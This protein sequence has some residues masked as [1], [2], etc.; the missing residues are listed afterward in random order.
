ME[1]LDSHKIVDPSSP[2]AVRVQLRAIL[3]DEIRQG[4]YKPNKRIP[5]ERELSERYKASRA[6]IREAIAELISEGVLFRA[7]GRG[8][9]VS[10]QSAALAKAQDQNRQIGFWI[11]EDIFHFIQAGYTR[12]LTGAEEICRASGYVL[13]FH[14]VTE[15]REAVALLFSESSGRPLAA[16]NL[17]AGGLRRSVMERI[18]QL[19]KPVVVVDPMIRTPVDTIDSV[20]IDYAAGT[21]EAVRHLVEL[22]HQE[23]GFIGF[24]GTVKYDAFWMSLEE[25][26]VH[27]HPRYAQFLDLPDVV[28]SVLTGF[29]SMNR[30]LAH[31]KRPTA[32]VVV[33]DHIAQ[34]ALEALS[35]SGLTVPE[36]M[37]L[38]GYDDIGQ[39]GL[40]LTTVR[41]D[42]VETGR[43][44]A[45]A[46]LDR[47]ANPS[48]PPRQIV[49][50]VTLVV[51]RSTGP[52]LKAA[53]VAEHVP[54]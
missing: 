15:D 26:G 18:E 4:V 51:R 25:L 23:I 47:I 32:V 17:V 10:D 53:Q 40:P 8:T 22:G 14:A 9:F 2:D 31:E 36:E 20:H 41:C 37:S 24:A 6:S 27:F 34:G 38:I 16:G 3:L 29:Q 46:L 54:A 44:A 35:V 12:I 19:G 39:A 28:P 45:R 49:V 52:C 33:N 48:L 43:L 13:A 11:N 1:S 42:L 21:R 50:P 5:S 30:L 7:G